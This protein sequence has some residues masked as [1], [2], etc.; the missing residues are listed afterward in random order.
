VGSKNRVGAFATLNGALYYYDYSGF[1][2]IANIPNNV[3]PPTSVNVP[4][5]ATLYGAELEA[6]FQLTPDDRLVLSPSVEEAKYT[7]SDL[8]AGFITD[9]GTIPNTPKFSAS[10]RYAHRFELPD[11]SHLSWEAD[12]HYQT[13]VLTDFDPS[14]YPTTNPSFQQK[15]Y[16]IINTSLVYTPASEKYTVSAYGKNLGNTLVKLTVYNANPP[17]AFI[18]D[19]LTFGVAFT[20]KI[21]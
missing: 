19:P 15:A 2:N 5:P 1:Q 4:L 14:N 21:Y 7:A 6:A 3:G 8:V 9:N 16:S 17:T 13:Q 20:A 10:G 12:G 11:G 18:G